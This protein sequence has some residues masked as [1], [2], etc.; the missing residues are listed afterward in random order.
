M[1]LIEPGREETVLS[2]LQNS[3]GERLRDLGALQC[4]GCGSGNVYFEPRMR[5]VI[6]NQCGKEEQ[7][8]RATLNS[9]GKV[10]YSKE[11]AIKFFTEGKLDDARHYAMKVMDIAKDN[12]PSLY[13]MAYHDECVMKKDGA[14]KSFFAETKKIEDVEY[15][16]VMELQKLFK[17]SAHILPEFETDVIELMA[18]NLQG[19]ED[20]EELRAFIDELCPYLIK[21]RHSIAFL[22]DKLL[23][24]YRDLAEHCDVPKTCLALIKAITENPDSPYT[25]NS[26]YL[27][28]KTKYF[29]DNFVVK[30]GYVINAMSNSDIKYKFI[31]A[32]TKTKEKYEEDAQM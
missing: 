4:R 19:E 18:V 11:N 22:T 26:F 15:S 7:Y 21:K 10:I 27:K 29:Y 31:N 9:N 2:L 5:K 8:T 17:M 3:K 24:M 14:L 16:E 28:A 20:K 32:Y 23:E 30:V 25:D 1:R 13:I 12:I 6:C